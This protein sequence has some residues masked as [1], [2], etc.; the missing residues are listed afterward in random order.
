MG[1][2]EQI[3]RIS[4]YFFGLFA[5]MLVLFFTI[6]DRSVTDALT[7]SQNDPQSKVIGEVNDEPIFYVEFEN[8][9]RERVKQQRSQMQDPTQMVNEAQIRSQV[10]NEMVEKLLLKQEAE[11]AGIFVTDN[12]IKDYLIENPPDFLKRSFM[13]TAG[14]FQRDLY[15]QLVTNPEDIVNYQF[16]D[17]SQVSEEQKN[18][19]V[20]SW[21]NDLMLVE[22]F[23]RSQILN[24]SMQTAVKSSSSLISPEYAKEHYIKEN[25]FADFSYVALKISDLQNANDIEVKDSEIKEY[26]DS[27]K[28]FYKQEPQRKIKYVSIPLTPSS[29]DTAKAVKRINRIMESLNSVSTPEEKDS[30]FDVK[31]SEYSGETHDYAY[32]TDVP[33]NVIRFIG[34]AEENVVLG[35]FRTQNGTSFFRV[36]DRRTGENISVKASH[37]LIKFGNNKDSAKAEAERIY[38]LAK[39]GDNFA[40]LAMQYSQDQGSRMN[41][42]DVGYFGKG[43]MVPEFEKASFAAEKGDIV[44]PV[45]TQFGYHIINVEDKNSDEVKY[46]EINIAPKISSITKN[47]LYRDAASIVTQVEDGTVMDSVISRINKTDKKNLRVRETR[48]FKKGVP[49]IG[50]QYISD[51]AFELE[52]GSV[53]KPDEYDNYGIVIAQVSEVREKGIAPLEDV[54][55]EITNKVLKAKK[56]DM[57]KDKANEVYAKANSLDSLSKLK[58][59]VDYEV[60]TLTNVKDNSYIAGLGKEPLIAY[61]IF[62]ETINTV[63]KPLRGENGYYIIQVH[64]RNIPDASKAEENLSQTILDLKQK[65][66][67]SAFMQWF[68]KVKENAEITDNRS[69]YYK[70]Y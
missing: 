25:S 5:V 31:L 41:G 60:N 13:D 12:M 26:Y 59:M 29:D 55:E 67:Q 38:K 65:A 51:K 22:D 17:L 7:G 48:F 36:D 54:R 21:R 15:L 11:K 40:S 2:F 58:N 4:P 53:I 42:G 28:E 45:E 6:G 10:W 34:M 35:P 62:K 33:P 61:N 68:S 66:S 16:R 52:L 9:V 1:T 20:Q 27:H 19:A 50:S 57:L 63:S 46:S 56:L 64:K 49:V 39:G 70:E 30:V 24:Q 44:G 8:Q 18:A 3:R 14:N 43:R 23:L 32:I 47:M 37:I 69:N